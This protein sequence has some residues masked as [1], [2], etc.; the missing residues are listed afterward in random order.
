MEEREPIIK[1][2]YENTTR[3]VNQ[4]WLT[5]PLSGREKPE[6][7]MLSLTRGHVQKNSIPFRI[8]KVE[9]PS[10]ALTGICLQTAGFR[11]LAVWQRRLEGWTGKSK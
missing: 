8:A 3:P 2:L 4:V 10:L 11:R 5:F 1:I 6:Q 9:S 7:K